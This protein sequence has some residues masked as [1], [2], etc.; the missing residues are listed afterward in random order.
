MEQ[1]DILL[2]RQF[3]RQ[4]GLE[5]DKIFSSGE[6]SMYQKLAKTQLNAKSASSAN[7]MVATETITPENS[8]NKWTPRRIEPI[9]KIE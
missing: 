9:V 3:A 5:L 6:P 2:F 7:Y 1:D 8:I 4:A